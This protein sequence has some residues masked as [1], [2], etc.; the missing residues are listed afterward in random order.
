M[1]LRAGTQEGKDVSRSKGIGNDY[2]EKWQMKV[3]LGGIHWILRLVEWRR[4]E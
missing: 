4:R 3:V 1:G 2:S